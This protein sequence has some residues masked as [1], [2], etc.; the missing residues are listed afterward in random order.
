MH[1]ALNT[2]FT[3]DGVPYQA[4]TDEE[5]IALGDNFLSKVVPMIEASQA[6]QNNGEIVIWNDETEDGNGPGY[7]SMEIV[8][9]KLAKGNAY[10]SILAYNHSSDL[11]TLQLIFG[12]SGPNGYLGDAA[13]ATPLTDL[14]VPGAI[15][16]GIPETGTWAMMLVGFA[17]LGFAGYRKGKIGN[18]AFSAG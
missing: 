11:A 16:S 2:N 18:L 17:G 13:G 8:I 10:D 12:V 15:P 6:F 3:Y 4:N 9:S 14:Y 1:S 5:Q 7:S